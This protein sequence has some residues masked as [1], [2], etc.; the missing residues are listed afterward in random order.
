MTWYG[1]H[2]GEK[3]A[4]LGNILGTHWEFERKIVRTHWEA[5]KY[6]KKSPPPNIKG[7]NK[8]LF[9]KNSNLVVLKILKKLS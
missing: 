5:E 7:K 3:I 8:I 9:V 2:V 6:E 1:E 4:K